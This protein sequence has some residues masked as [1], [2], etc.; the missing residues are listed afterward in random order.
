MF[1][2][3]HAETVWAI[4]GGLI[5]G[6][7]VT[8][9]I[10]WIFYRKAEKPKRLAYEVKSSNRI[11]NAPGKQR[12]QLKVFYQD[13]KLDNP[14]IVVVRLGN[15]GRKPI[16]SA[17]LDSKP[18]TIDY[19]NSRV[20][21]SEVV[22]RSKRDL[23]EHVEIDPD[24]SNLVIIKPQLFRSREWFDLQCLT[25]GDLDA[26]SVSARFSGVLEAVNSEKLGA[27]PAAAIYLGMTLLA[28]T[29]AF[30]WLG[31]LLL[32][33][34][35]DWPTWTF[36]VS[37]AISAW[38]TGGFLGQRLRERSGWSKPDSVAEEIDLVVNGDPL[39]QAAH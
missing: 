29:L 11:I 9:I 32:Q 7:I 28:I 35:T 19:G 38:A 23:D 5:G 15:L 30:F 4:L 1:W 37:L 2:E 24:Q 26:P 13:V 14:N 17:D 34:W 16:L 22:Q 31:E 12:K 25:D 10:T 39:D 21:A 8:W 36:G 6:I 27:K 20:L 18:I 33:P 3:Q